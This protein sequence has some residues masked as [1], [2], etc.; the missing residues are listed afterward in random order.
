M[1]NLI[2]ESW[3]TK[4]VISAGSNISVRR[5]FYLIKKNHIRFLPIVF[6]EKLIGVV[7]DRDLRYPITKLKNIHGVYRLSE[8]IKVRQIMTTEVVTLSPNDSIETAAILAVKRNISGFPVINNVR[9][10][11]LLGVLTISDIL[12]SMIS[13]MEDKN[14]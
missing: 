11:K 5:A 8:D 1:K 4:N 2:V 14:L 3:M 6:Q 12:R 13:I 7:T 9:E 10:K